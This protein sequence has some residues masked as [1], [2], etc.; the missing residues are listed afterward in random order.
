MV[1]IRADRHLKLPP[2]AYHPE[3]QTLTV[4]VYFG[5]EFRSM[6]VATFIGEVAVE[7]A[8]MEREVDKKKN[9]GKRKA[10]DNGKGKTTVYKEDDM[11]FMG[12]LPVDEVGNILPGG[13]FVGDLNDQAINNGN[14]EGIN[15]GSVGEL[16]E[17]TQM[18]ET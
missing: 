7:P 14:D 15:I 5:G 6:P 3:S 17:D 8:G 1:M 18:Q 4:A 13:P 9:K 11:Q 16:A 12:N 2:P 10:R